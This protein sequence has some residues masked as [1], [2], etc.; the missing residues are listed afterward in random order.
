MAGSIGGAGTGIAHKVGCKCRKLACLW[1]YCKCFSTST[2]CSP[3]FCCVGCM[4]R[5]PGGGSMRG[6]PVTWGVVDHWALPLW[7]PCVIA[8]GNGSG[9]VEDQ[10][11]GRDTE[12]MGRGRGYP[13]L[14]AVHNLAF[15]GH[16][17]PPLQAPGDFN[18]VRNASSS[19]G[20]MPAINAGVG[21]KLNQAANH[22]LFAVPLPSLHRVYPMPDL[23]QDLQ[24]G[25]SGPSRSRPPTSIGVQPRS[26]HRHD[27]G[28]GYCQPTSRPTTAISDLY[29]D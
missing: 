26:D 19:T 6:H 5:A 21:M 24:G 1:K 16:A 25:M 23:H 18:H 10:V 9:G 17:L 3:N 22:L 2:W 27:Q 8:V 13:V 12:K 29:D 4:N 14:S 15:L 20:Q 11:I 7:P 28:T